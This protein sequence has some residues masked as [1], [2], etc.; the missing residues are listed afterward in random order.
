M[1]PWEVDYALL[2]F[3][4]FKKSKYYLNL[5]EDEII[6]SIELNLSKKI[7]NWNKSKLPKQ[8]FIDKYNQI[9]KL[10]NEDYEVEGNI[11]E[12]PLLRGHLQHQREAIKPD[13]DFY[14]SVCPD[15]Y[16]SEHLLSTYDSSIKANY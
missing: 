1:M 10:L 6:F 3:T 7:F 15:T 5:D 12:G 2:S 4:Q 13:I 8:F 11:Y 14:I 9:L 16:F